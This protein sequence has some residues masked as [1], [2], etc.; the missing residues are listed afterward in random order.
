MG[1]LDW[2][3]RSAPANVV[4]NQLN[5]GTTYGG[6]GWSNAELTMLSLNRNAV[7]GSED[8]N[9]IFIEDVKDTDGR[10]YR[11]EYQTN[12]AGNHATAWCRHSPWPRTSQ[13][14]VHACHLFETGQICIGGN[15]S[16]L[17]TVVLRARY[18]CAAYSYLREHGTWP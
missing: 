9:V 12:P 7:A 3:L 13:F 1:F 14:S 18:W 10:M 6:Y 5:G 15:S 17:R 8:G 2:L 16:D 4:R 11:I